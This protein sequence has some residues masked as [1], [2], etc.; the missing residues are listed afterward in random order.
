MTSV[1][2]NEIVGHTDILFLCIDTLRYDVASAEE[3]SGGT[4]VLNQYG[5]W[6]ACQGQLYISVPSRHVCG[7]SALSGRRRTDGGA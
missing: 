1:N 6:L 4:P 7:I 3:A 5:P 2:M